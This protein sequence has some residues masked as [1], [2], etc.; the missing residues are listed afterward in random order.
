[1]RIDGCAYPFLKRVVHEKKRTE[2][3]LQLLEPGLG[4]NALPPVE[5]VGVLTFTLTYIGPEKEH[6][7]MAQLKE[8]VKSECA[9]ACVIHGHLV[10]RQDMVEE[11]AIYKRQS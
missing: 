3:V 5:M 11:I 9:C 10:H 6:L 8:P 2:H 4:L 7:F 1:M